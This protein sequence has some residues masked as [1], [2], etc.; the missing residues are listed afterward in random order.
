FK[1]V[2]NLKGKLLD[3]LNLKSSN[4]IAKV[5][6]KDKNKE[7]E[8]LN[9]I[10]E[11]KQDAILEIDLQDYID[12]AF[13]TNL[14]GA[15]S[16]YVGYENGGILTEHLIA[17][18]FSIIVLKNFD[19]ANIVIKEIINRAIESGNITDNKRRVISLKNTIF[20]IENK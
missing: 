7:I 2:N 6:T 11:V 1:D 5:D 8:Y 12:N 13:F 10:F 4:I 15:P 19:T 9:N 3:Y 14:I 16:G 17:H 18:P 20:I